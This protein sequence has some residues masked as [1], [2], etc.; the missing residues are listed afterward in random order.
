MEAQEQEK[1]PVTSYNE[2]C[3][4]FDFQTDQKYCVDLR[5]VYQALKL[6]FVKGHGCDVYNNKEV[7]N[8]DEGKTNADDETEEEQEASVPLVTHVNNILLLLFSNVE[9]Y[10]YNQQIYNSNVLYAHR[11]YISNSFKGPV[12][13]YKVVSHC[14]GYGY[15]ETID[16]LLEA[17]MSDPYS[18]R[19]IE[20]LS[21]PNSSF[22]YGKLGA[23]FSS[24][25]KC[26]SQI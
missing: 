1:Y 19:R 11:S 22:L 8:D 5:Q 26:C 2:N 6:K 14:Y 10:I 3:T 21:R 15:E 17:P 23:V 25:P 12:S 7:K 20:L 18:P 24:L 13:E 4:E 9:V 16:H